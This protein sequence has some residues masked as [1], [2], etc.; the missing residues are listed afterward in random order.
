MY[1][2]KGSLFLL[3]TLFFYSNLC[4]SQTLTARPTHPLDWQHMLPTGESPGW[5]SDSWVEFEAIEANYWAATATFRNK[6]TNKELTFTADYEQTS[7]FVELGKALSKKFAVAIE[8]PYAGRSEGTTTDRI[9]NDFHELLHFDDFG[10]T[11]H[12]YGQKIFETST[13]G[14][15]RGPYEAPSG[16][17]NIKL[18][19]K[20]WP[21]QWKR[22]T[23]LGFSFQVKVPTENEQK[24]MTSGYFDYSGLMNAA[25]PMGAKSTFYTT[26]G[27]TY[28][29][30]N[31]MFN[32]WPRNKFL[33]LIDFTF[34]VGISEKWGVI[35]DFS[36]R[37]P[38]MKRKDIEI[39]YS[40][41]TAKEQAYEKLASGYNSLVEY[42]GS[43]M[44]GVRRNFGKNNV[45]LAYFLEDW[46]PGDR[47]NNHDM[48]YSSGQPDFGI[49]TKFIL[50][51]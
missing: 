5:R 12:P 1:F 17:G 9:I 15:R 7:V 28:A 4:Q 31:W 34:D 20:Y 46:G 3:V 30:K 44:I 13:N 22:N 21:I 38:F 51:L 48:V 43:Q 35:L 26:L 6:K 19:L 11:L 14:V 45:W 50:S 37:S 16:F 49:G 32:D 8:V 24:G 33:Y 41:S 42:R 2:L 18:K 29:E 10:R 40:T 36:F 47:D 27:V 23:G 25:F 39:E